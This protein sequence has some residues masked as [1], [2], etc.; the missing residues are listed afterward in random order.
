MMSPSRSNHTYMEY[1]A[2]LQKDL[3]G[4]V[5]A[6]IEA[7]QQMRP[8]KKFFGLTLDE[9]RQKTRH[10]MEARDELA[11]L[12]QRYGHAMARRDQAAPDLL[13][14]VQGVVLSVQGDPEE[15]QNGELYGAMGYVPKNQRSRGRRRAVVAQTAPG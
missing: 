7:W 11:E 10:Y 8:H 12:T 4:R 15:T 14:L 6:V 2:M 3:G 1:T 5:K 9:F 13:L